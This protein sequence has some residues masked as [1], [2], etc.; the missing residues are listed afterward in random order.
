M[1]TCIRC[2]ALHSSRQLDF[3][4]SLNIFIEYMSGT[5]VSS[6][7]RLSRVRRAA[8]RLRTL[9]R[10]RRRLGDIAFT[11]SLAWVVS[12]DRLDTTCSPTV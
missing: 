10:Q 4:Y 6:C 3:L 5:S 1:L 2:S 8:L 11:S 9:R 7:T 12:A